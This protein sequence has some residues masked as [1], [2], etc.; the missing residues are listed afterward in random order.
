MQTVSPVSQ[1]DALCHT[2]TLYGSGRDKT[3]LRDK[4]AANGLTIDVPAYNN[5]KSL[6]KQ[7]QPHWRHSLAN[8]KVVSAALTAE[9]NV[10][11]VHSQRRSRRICDGP[12]PPEADGSSSPLTR[13][14]LDV[15]GLVQSRAIHMDHTYK[16]L[17]IG[18][19]GAGKTSLVQRYVHGFY[20]KDYKATL[21]GNPL[22][23]ASLPI[24]L[25]PGSTN[26]QSVI[27]QPC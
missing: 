6:T 8:G 16:L 17:V 3:R 21:G 22:Y 25:V 15:E 4:A 24:H 11:S 27:K 1:T 10:L 23:T 5:S 18:D 13:E 20:N 9:K 19:P 26:K 2:H 12:R 14:Q 7:L